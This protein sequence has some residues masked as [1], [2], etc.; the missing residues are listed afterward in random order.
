MKRQTTPTPKPL[1]YT[2][3]GVRGSPH[4]PAVDFEVVG[5]P[6]NRQTLAGMGLGCG[7]GEVSNDHE[8]NR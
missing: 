1:L 6:G 3:E 7:E 2:R 4:H 5:V 8:E